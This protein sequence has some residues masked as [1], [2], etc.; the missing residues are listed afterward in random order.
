MSIIRDQ[1]SDEKLD[2]IAI[3]DKRGKVKAPEAKFGD[4]IAK[5]NLKANKLGKPFAMHAAR[6]EFKDHYE[7]EKKRVMREFGSLKLSEVKEFKPDWNKYSDTKNFEILEE[8]EIH[9]EHLSKRYNLQVYVKKTV[10]KFKGYNNKCTM[11]EEPF[12][13]V[14]RAKLALK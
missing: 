11:M 3:S 12:D 6:A 4:K 10:Y 9:D 7:L 5:Q 8:D 13:A 2:F 1:T 14:Q